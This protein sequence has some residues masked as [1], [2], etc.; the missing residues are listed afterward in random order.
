MPHPYENRFPSLYAKYKNQHVNIGAILEVLDLQCKH[1][2]NLEEL[3][4]AV[5]AGGWQGSYVEFFESCI[6]NSGGIRS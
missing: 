1:L 6:K 3:E 5:N 4:Q 2:F